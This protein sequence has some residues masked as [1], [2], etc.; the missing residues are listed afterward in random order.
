MRRT[1]ICFLALGLLFPWGGHANETVKKELGIEGDWQIRN[2]ETKEPT[3]IIHIWGSNGQYFGK[4]KKV[5]PGQAD[6]ITA[7]SACRDWRHN[8]PILGLLIIEGLV[9]KA[10]K[11]YEQGTILDPRS[12]KMYRCAAKV[13][14]DGQ[15][16]EMRGYMGFSFIG[17]RDIWY[18]V[19]VKQRLFKKE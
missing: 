19:P 14:L 8:R 6:L 5:Y 4:I 2:S 1:L 16:L 12:G 3:S 11:Q 15:Q 17:A 9:E 7:C 10:K 18:R 13:S